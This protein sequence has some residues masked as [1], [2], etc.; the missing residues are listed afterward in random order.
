MLFFPQLAEPVK[1]HEFSKLHPHFVPTGRNLSVPLHHRLATSLN[2]LLKSSARTTARIK[3]AYC[4]IMREH[5]NGKFPTRKSMRLRCEPERSESLFVQPYKVNGAFSQISIEF[6]SNAHPL[7]ALILIMIT[8][9]EEKNIPWTLVY[10]VVMVQ[11]GL[12]ALAVPHFAPF[13]LFFISSP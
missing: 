10:L 4:M 11:A 2:E 3:L 8:A 1:P 7:S 13:F 9:D 6:Q 5:L 12:N